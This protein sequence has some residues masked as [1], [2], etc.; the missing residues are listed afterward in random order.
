MSTGVGTIPVSRGWNG[1]AGVGGPRDVDPGGRGDAGPRELAWGGCGCGCGDGVGE[2]VSRLPYF[3]GQVSNKEMDQVLRIVAMV[4]GLALLG[5][6]VVGVAR[7]WDGA[8]LAAMFAVG[9]FVVLVVPSSHRLQRLAT[10]KD[11]F[12]A[13]FGLGGAAKDAAARLG[14]TKEVQAYAFVH[15][16]LGD[17]EFR[18]AKIHLQDKLIETIQAAAGASKVDSNA[19]SEIFEENVPAARAVALGLIR[20]NYRSASPEIIE[21]AI[22]DSRSANEQ[23][24]ALLAIRDNWNSNDAS[25]K[26]RLVQAIRENAYVSDG[27]DR[28]AIADQIEYLYEEESSRT[29]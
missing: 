23:Y 14:L 9:A 2:Q 26:R 3:P 6:G 21:S 16:E 13:E 28:Q 4:A 11:G 15:H 1:R 29:V 25:V 27:G 10:G 19:L 24:H 22:T 8:G 20:G 5:V 17:E 18:S 7:D 12:E